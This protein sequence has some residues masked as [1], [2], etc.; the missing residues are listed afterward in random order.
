MER[1]VADGR[2]KTRWVGAPLIREIIDFYFVSRQ[3]HCYVGSK[4]NTRTFPPC[5]DSLPHDNSRLN[6]VQCVVSTIPSYSA[7]VKPG[8]Y[9]LFARHLLVF[10]LLMHCQ[11]F[12][13]ID[14]RQRANARHTLECRHY[15]KPSCR[16]SER[17]L[18][19]GAQN[20]TMRILYSF[21]IGN[22]TMNSMQTFEI[23]RKMRSDTCNGSVSSFLTC[24]S[25]LEL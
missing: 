19:A 24:L 8:A 20:N 16:Y 18:L 2:K 4:V 25:L 17:P 15:A 3:D 14:N 22:N 10:A 6:H 21:S 23:S 1:L 12:T 11:N 9:N 13:S 7:F 5:L